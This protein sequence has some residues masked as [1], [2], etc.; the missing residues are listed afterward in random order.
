MRY[1]ALILGMSLLLSGV[2]RGD[3]VQNSGGT[4][5][6]ST[7]DGTWTGDADFT[8]EVT[9]GSVV[10]NG[11]I[12]GTSLT[13]TG[14]V[15]VG[16]DLS[17]TGGVGGAGDGG[18]RV[19]DV[20]SSSVY[21]ELIRTPT[22]YIYA[23]MQAKSI[24]YSS[25]GSVHFFVQNDTQTTAGSVGKDGWNGLFITTNTG[26]E[27]RAYD[28]IILPTPNSR[29]D[30]TN[31]SYVTTTSSATFGQC[32]FSA[33]ADNAS[34][35]CEYRLMV[36]LDLDTSVALVLSSMTYS[37]NGADTSTH[38]YVISHSTGSDSGTRAQTMVNA[39]TINDSADA[40]G[41]DGDIEVVSGT[42]LTSWAGSLTP[43]G[44]WVIRWGRDGDSDASA[45]VSFTGPMQIR[46]GIKKDSSR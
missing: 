7:F 31:A 2:V 21:A 3:V 39:I 8:G 19:A 22:D 46:Y 35:Y 45:T 10:S 24:V 6:G 5:G 32:Q 41:V 14:N 4:G 26:S 15:T 36:P 13:T 44:Y 20:N 17:V 25:S 27:F 23:S 42:A 33:T 28:Y 29:T 18:I 1:K 37:L 11:A 12:T 38:T 9:A 40:S 43:G 30:G 16:G 34:N